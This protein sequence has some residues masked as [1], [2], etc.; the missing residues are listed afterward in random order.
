M[1]TSVF[2]KESHSFIPLCTSNVNIKACK[3][4]VLSSDRTC[5]LGKA[6]LFLDNWNRRS[7]AGLCYSWLSTDLLNNPEPFLASISPTVTPSQVGQVQ[8]C[9]FLVSSRQVLPDFLFHLLPLGAWFGGQHIASSNK[10]KYKII[11]FFLLY[12]DGGWRESVKQAMRF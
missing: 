8:F 11:K 1:I 4:H 12:I 5:L 10:P 3:W 2:T 7:R 6:K 9:L